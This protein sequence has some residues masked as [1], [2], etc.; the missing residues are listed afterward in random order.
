MWVPY[1]FGWWWRVPLSWLYEA[2]TFL[3]TGDTPAERR[4]YMQ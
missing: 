2:W 3:T 4:R 1:Y